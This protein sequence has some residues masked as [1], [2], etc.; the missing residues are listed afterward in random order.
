M[1]KKQVLK[2]I[3]VFMHNHDNYYEDLKLDGFKVKIEE[4]VGGEGQGEHT[5]IVF[6]ISDKEN[7]MFVKLN[8]YYDS[9]E[10]TEWDY[11]SLSEVISYEKTVRDWKKVK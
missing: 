11:N 2:D 8:G 9:Y 10:G 1:N 4:E 3:A 5:H 7:S 6:K